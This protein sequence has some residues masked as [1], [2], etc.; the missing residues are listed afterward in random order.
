MTVE[1]IAD[2]PIGERDFGG[3]RIYGEAHHA[4][5]PDWTG[6]REYSIWFT[7][8]LTPTQRRIRFFGLRSPFVQND[9]PRVA[10]ALVWAYSISMIVRA[11]FPGARFHYRVEINGYEP[12]FDFQEMEGDDPFVFTAVGDG[13][14]PL[15]EGGIPV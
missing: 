6:G 9:L 15:S 7:F 14:Y 13:N 5:Y 1:P 4:W 12:G 3:V 8:R 11:G 10:Q 2:I